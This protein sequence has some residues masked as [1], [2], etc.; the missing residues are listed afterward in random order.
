MPQPEPRRVWPVGHACDAVTALL[1]RAGRLAGRA[2]HSGVPQPE[3]AAAGPG[4]KLSLG[5][6]PSGH[7][8]TVTRPCPDA[9][10]GPASL[11]RLSVLIYAASNFGTLSC[12]RKSFHGQKARQKE[13]DDACAASASY[14]INI[15]FGGNRIYRSKADF[16]NSEHCYNGLLP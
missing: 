14:T 15:L 5:R 4:F 13:K 10:P 8:R 16:Q 2:G 1:P 11:S 9:G 3:P 7:C 6:L 12:S